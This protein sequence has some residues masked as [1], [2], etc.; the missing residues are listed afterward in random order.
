MRISSL[1]IIGLLL[2]TAA[3]HALG[4]QAI[5]VTGVRIVV[6]SGTLQLTGLLWTPAGSGPFPAVLFTHG[7]G[8]P[9]PAQ[10]E[11]L[12]PVFAKHGYVFLYLF[13]RGAGLSSTQG[14]NM[15]DVLDR[16]ERLD[17]PI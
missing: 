7:G 1:P 5:S 10:A 9:D 6:S 4:Q 11:V 13:R 2:L 3:P 12:G 16:E 17:P 15:R 14:E 8:R